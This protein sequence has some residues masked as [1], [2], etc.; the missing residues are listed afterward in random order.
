MSIAL[1]F[2]QIGSI[3]LFWFFF[4]SITKKL[5]YCVNMKN[6]SLLKHVFEQKTELIS[7]QCILN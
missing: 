7:D 6:L 3:R 2:V 4:F 1:T 5:F